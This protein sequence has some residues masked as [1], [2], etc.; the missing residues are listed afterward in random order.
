MIDSF[1]RAIDC[2]KQLS[3]KGYCGQDI[4]IF[5]NN[6]ILIH[7]SNIPRLL[8]LEWLKDIALCHSRMT[9]GVDSF[10]QLCG[11]VA[12]MFRRTLLIKTTQTA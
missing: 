1:Q 9:N 10:V 6:Y 8:A 3:R 2:L 4:V 11:L 12:N 5:L 7:D